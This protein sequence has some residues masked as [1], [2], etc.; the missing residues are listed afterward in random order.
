MFKKIYV[1]NIIFIFI[2]SYKSYS[3]VVVEKISR[4]DSLFSL[5]KYEEAEQLYQD[6]FYNNRT[7]SEKMLVQLALI[8]SQ[9]KDYVA[10]LYWLNLYFQVNPNAKIAEKVENTAN[11]YELTGYDLSDSRWF[12]VYYHH[13]YKFIA[14]FCCV[15]LS[16]LLILFFF[17]KQR[18]VVFRR[19]GIFILLFLLI[20]ILLL[21]VV[22]P[23]KEA[24][25]AA[26]STYLMLAPSSASQVAGIAPKGQ[27]VN[28]VGENDVWLEV[29]WNKQKVFV[30]K[31][32]VYF[33]DLF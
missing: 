4:A 7:Y 33:A 15:V 17:S 9:K 32:Q 20:S 8:A 27:K 1:L 28:V 12:L 21:N 25:I 19:N 24:V 3:Q 10:Y 2:F 23:I 14:L 31:T 30:K 5:N 29:I 18:I 6:I 16:A 22:P 11:A 13:Y 26:D